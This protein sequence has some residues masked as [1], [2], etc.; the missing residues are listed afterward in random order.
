VENVKHFT[1]GIEIKQ[2]HVVYFVPKL[3]TITNS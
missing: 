3:K 1:N 2:W